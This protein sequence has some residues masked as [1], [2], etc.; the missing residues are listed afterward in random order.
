MSRARCD[1]RR[2]CASFPFSGGCGAAVVLISGLV[3]AA[4]LASRR[5]AEAREAGAERA[6]GRKKG[7]ERSPEGVL[8]VRL[9]ALR[10]GGDKGQGSAR[11]KAGCT[12]FDSAEGYPTQPDKARQR[13]KCPLS[14]N[15]ATCRFAPLPAGTYAVA[16]I[17]DENGNGTLDTNW[18]GIPT[19]GTVASNHA[20]GTMGPP[21]FEDAR[22][23][24]QGKDQTLVLRM[25]Y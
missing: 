6:G 9:V 21:K 25:G 8:S 12:V 11:G 18:M 15:S 1:L 22:F 14:H 10:G 5:P 2:V 23:E 19:E 13:R 24:F 20:K 16:C 3:L 4:L 17:H 7:S